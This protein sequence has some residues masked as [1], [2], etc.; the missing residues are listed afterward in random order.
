MSSS[1]KISEEARKNFAKRV[2]STGCN[3][4]KS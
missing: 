2:I 4:A 1:I 3:V